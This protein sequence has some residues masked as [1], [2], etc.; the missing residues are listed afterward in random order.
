MGSLVHVWSGGLWNPS[1]RLSRTVRSLCSST[2]W[3]AGGSVANVL[4]VSEG[5]S[6]F[7]SGVWGGVY[8]AWNCTCLGRFWAENA[9]FFLLQDP[10]LPSF[11]SSP[12]LVYILRSALHPHVSPFIFVKHAHTHCLLASSQ[13]FFERGR[14]RLAIYPLQMK[15]QR[16]REVPG[17]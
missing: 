3:S 17:P 8:A 14:A 16:P 10:I 13:I 5:L 12:V 2:W 7:S 15:K 11:F 9:T 1:S 6:A 4:L